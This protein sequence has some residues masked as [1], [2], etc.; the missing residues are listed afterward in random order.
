MPAELN[1]NEA[2]KR[3][4]LHGEGPARVLA[5]PGSGKTLVI[6]HRLR[7]LLKERNVSPDSVLVITFTKAASLQMQERFQ[8]KMGGVLYPVQ[9]GTFHAVFYHILKQSNLDFSKEIISESDKFK[10]IGTMISSFQRQYPDVS[11]PSEE[12]WIKEIGRYKNTGERFEAAA[13]SVFVERN[14]FLQMYQA[15]NQRLAR[16][17]KLDFDDMAG[18]CIRLFQ[19]K[20]DILAFWQKRFQYILVDEFQDCNGPQYEAVK[21]LAGE[22]RNLFVVGDDDQSIYGFR[23]ASPGIMK[24]FKEDYPESEDIWLAVNYRS[25]IAIVQTAGLCI[26]E[27]KERETKDIK[28]AGPIGKPVILKGIQ[29]KKE[30]GEYLTEQ[31]LQWKAQGRAYEEA[32][33]ICRTNLELEEIAL[34]LKEKEIPFWRKEKRKVFLNI[35]L[36]VIW[37]ATFVSQEEKKAGVFFYKLSIIRCVI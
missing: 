13:P 19:E 11:L 6:V 24:K 17:N 21:L 32:A 30:E 2:Q 18:M 15:Y 4:I 9:F 3:A 27:N 5:G 25:T 23:G 16:E 29:T 34:L 7:Y 31:L 20:P 36:C 10:L 35:L 28:A 33:I 1:L 14:V 12:T 26:G 22:K 8:H 37:K